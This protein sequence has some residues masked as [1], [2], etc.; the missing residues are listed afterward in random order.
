MFLNVIL[1]LFHKIQDAQLP[2]EGGPSSSAQAALDHDLLSG[3]KKMVK[4]K[5]LKCKSNLLS[6]ISL[7]TSIACRQ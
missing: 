6:V 4:V 3:S 2:V 1:I 7:K 5:I